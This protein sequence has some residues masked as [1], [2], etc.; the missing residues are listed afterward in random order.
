MELGNWV[1]G[2]SEAIRGLRKGDKAIIGLSPRVLYSSKSSNG[3]MD[4]RKF[5]ASWLVVE[6]EIV[7]VKNTGVHLCMYHSTHITAY[8][9]IE[10]IPLYTLLHTPNRL[11]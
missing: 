10:S 2:L 1:G 6:V 11:C 5:P 8:T 3:L 7:K 4:S 9:V